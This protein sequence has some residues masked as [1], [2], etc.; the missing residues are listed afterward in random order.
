MEQATTMLGLR[1]L[2]PIHVGT[3]D[4]RGVIDLAIQREKQTNWPVV[5]GSSVKGALRELAA[6]QW[7]HDALDVAALFGPDKPTADTT[8]AGALLVNDMR[9]LALP[10]PALNTV[11]KWITCPQALRRL[12]RDC[13]MF[14]IGTDLPPVPALANDDALSFH[15]GD[16]ARIFLREYLFNKR[17]ATPDEHPIL[18]WFADLFGAELGEEIGS[19][20]LI[21]SDSRFGHLAQTATAIAPHIKLTKNKTTEGGALWFEET[22]PCETLMYLPLAS[23]PE[24]LSSRQ[25]KDSASA[26]SR[27]QLLARTL[28]LFERPYLRIGANET[29][30]MG[31][32]FVHVAKPCSAQGE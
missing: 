2:A 24:R 7:G 1:A 23:E 5:F 21:V 28:S 31:W 26:Q 19:R 32:F 20:L 10:V 9:L 17:Q 8:R 22:L 12:R 27:H 18:Q 25:Q 11:F 14:A 30:G 4:L 3:E 16:P 15:A 29:T 13:Q 6:T